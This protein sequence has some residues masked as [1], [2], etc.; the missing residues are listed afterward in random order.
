[1][2]KVFWKIETCPKCTTFAVKSLDEFWGC[3]NCGDLS[4]TAINNFL[5]GKCAFCGKPIIPL[6]D[7][8]LCCGNQPKYLNTALK[9]Y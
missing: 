6:M 2:K 4:E 3:L 5:A 1:M 8:C 7:A 9:N